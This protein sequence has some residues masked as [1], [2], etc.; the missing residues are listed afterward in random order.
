MGAG[1]AISGPP[2]TSAVGVVGRGTFSVAS[3]GTVSTRSSCSAPSQSRRHG[4]RE[5]R[6][7]RQI[8]GNGD[9]VG[10]ISGGVN[11]V[12]TLTMNDLVFGTGATQ[13]FRVTSAG[14]PAALN[15]GG[16]S[17]GTPGNPANNNYLRV[18]GSLFANS[19][20]FGGRKSSRPTAS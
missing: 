13:S 4:L 2:E 15:T 9:P 6:V 19:L 8:N 12:G 10:S 20:L 11:G 7:P 5:H 16:S 1:G 3:G 17:G 14:T 18:T